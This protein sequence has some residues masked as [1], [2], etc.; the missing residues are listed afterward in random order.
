MQA[1]SSGEQAVQQIIAETSMAIGCRVEVR[2]YD[3]RAVPMRHEHAAE[4]CFDPG[5]RRLVIARLPATAP[6]YASLVLFSHPDSEPVGSGQPW[7]TRPFELTA[8]RG[9]LFGWGIADALAGCAAGIAVLENLARSSAPRGEVWFVSAPSKRHGRGMAAALHGGLR[10]DAAIYL[11]PAESGRGLGEIKAMTLGQA[12]FRI[13]LSGMSPG[14]SEPSQAPFAHLGVN[15]LDKAV[16]L[17]AALNALARARAEDIAFA[18]TARAVGRAANLHVAAICCG[19]LVAPTRLAGQCA[20]KGA[21]SFPP[22][23]RL[24]DTKRELE[25]MLKHHAQ[26]DPWLSAH[27][28][29]L[30]WLSGTEAAILSDA[31]PLCVA[32]D[33]VLSRITGTRPQRNVLHAASDIRSPMQQA[34]MPCIGFG[35]LCGDLTQNGGQG[36]WVDEADFGAMIAAATELTRRWCGAPRPA[37]GAASAVKANQRQL[38]NIN[39]GGQT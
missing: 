21:M 33:E 18:P 11:H 38:S 16:E 31:H 28:P 2:D 4:E 26:A 29:R 25:N 36:E 22:G 7:R 6:G 15:P 5:Q 23:Q 8:D 27:P 32:A 17:H 35:C 3:P 10:A 13:T 20:I 9:R 1:Q 30:E 14:I 34:D 24:Q 19:D 39:A 12:E 37:A